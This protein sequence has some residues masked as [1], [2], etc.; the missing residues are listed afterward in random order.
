MVVKLAG[1]G[2]LIWLG[3]QTIWHRQRLSSNEASVPLPQRARRPWLTGFT[4]NLLN[5]KIAVF[6]TSLLPQLVPSGAPHAITLFG[7]VIAHAVLTVP[8]LRFTVSPSIALQ[9][10]SGVHVFAKL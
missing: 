4:N 10:F 8:G 9:E 2:Y 7:L 6:Y 3:I 1:V 5:P